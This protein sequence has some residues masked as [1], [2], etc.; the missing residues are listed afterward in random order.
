MH[1]GHNK[2]QHNFTMA[3]QQLT[4]TEEQLDLGITITRDLKWQK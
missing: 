1:I 3:N 4:A 2:I